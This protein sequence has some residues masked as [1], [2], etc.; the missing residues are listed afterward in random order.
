MKEQPLASD[1][2]DCSIVIPIFNEK[3][4]IPLLYRGLKRETEGIGNKFE[5]IF[6][7]DGSWDNSIAIL[8][9]E[10][11]G[12][13]CVRMVSLQRHL[14]KSFALQSGFELARGQYVMTLDGDCQ[15][16]PADIRLFLEKIKDG[17][18]D[19]LCG[20]RTHRCDP[21][22]KIIFSKLANYLRRAVFAES[23]HDVGCSFR[24]YSRES[25]KG[26]CLKREQHRFITAILKKKGFS[27][28]EVA[29]RHYPRLSGK[30]KY[31]IWNRLVK[32]IPD[33]LS[34]ILSK[35]QHR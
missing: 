6:V 16:D 29:V 19:V 35:K 33:F 27:I 10:T 23:I 8:Q 30:S 11:Q 5:I 21:F 31:G 18:F 14:G 25:L 4:N 34:L 22:S 17:R 15:Y 1:T 2:V 3:D 28:G 7:D 20:W 26:I 24:I 12:D 9:K 13:Y 32:S